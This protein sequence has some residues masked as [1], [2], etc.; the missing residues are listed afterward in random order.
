M[1]KVYLHGSYFGNNFGDVLLV[2]LFAK[3]IKSFGYEVCLPYASDFYY[4]D[5]QGVFPNTEGGDYIAGVFCG[6]GYLGE[7]AHNKLFWSVRNFWR[8]G[9]ALRL[10]SKKSLPYGVFAAGFGPITYEPFFSTAKKIIESASTV[11]VRDPESKD[12]LIQYGVN[13]DIA[14]TSDAVL[15]LSESDIPPGSIEY[16]QRFLQGACQKPCRF[17][18]IHITD[19][20]SD[21]KVFSQICSAIEVMAAEYSDAFFVL[22]CDGVSRRGRKLKQQ[23]DAETVAQYLPVGRF[24]FAPYSNHWNMVALLNCLNVVVTSKLHVGI[25]SSVLGKNVLSFPYHSKTRRF[26]SQINAGERCFDGEYSIGK[27]SDFMRSFW[28]SGGVEIPGHVRELSELNFLKLEN[29]LRS[30]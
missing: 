19:K 16:A 27:V 10:F 3:R 21:K 9:R 1:K 15:S 30:I 13:K 23:V 26:Y 18:G 2:D 12:F 22:L 5:I 14:V 28:S 17:I 20:F 25:V 29:F 8:H 24:V 7:P 4:S 6:G 11:C